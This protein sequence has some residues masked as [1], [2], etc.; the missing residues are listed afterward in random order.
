MFAS[1]V[2]FYSILFFLLG[3]FLASLGFV[4]WSIVF[5]AVLISIG[6]LVG[7]WL[8]KKRKFFWPFLF[9]LP[10]IIGFFYY[11]L[12]DQ[13]FHAVEIPFNQERI[14]SGVVVKEPKLSLTSQEIM[15]KLAAPEKGKVLIKLPRYPTLT[16]GDSLIFKG[17]IEKTSDNFYGLSLAK[18][19]ING[20]SLFPT[21]K[22]KGINQGSVF[23]SLL[24]AVKIRVIEIFRKILPAEQAAFLSGLILGDRGD[25]SANFKK[26]MNLSGTTHLIALSGYNISIISLTVMAIFLFFFSR[27]WAFI[28]TCLI[29]TGFVIMTGAE[30]SVVRAAIMGGLALLAQQVGRLYSVRNAIMLAAFIMVLAN[31]K[32]L[33]FDVG[34]QLSFCALLGIVYLKPV[35]AGLSRFFNQPGFL[36]WRDNFLT[37]ASAQLVVLPILVGAFGQFSLTSLLAN[38]LILELIP[39]TMALG[40]LTAGVGFFS[41]YLSLVLGWLVFGLLWIETKIIHWFAVLS[42]PLK[43]NFSIILIVLYYLIISL[44]ILYRKKYVL[45]LQKD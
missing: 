10:V 6:L 16:Y 15:V 43:I 39:V 32:V 26:M 24:I 37:T 34:F 11:R 13:K 21:I 40:F 18:E 31:P 9:I 5:A 3:I 19:K 42:V 36:A 12:D 7:F 35:L 22:K 2:F 45:S 20:I 17:R 30:A 38:V 29:I 27:R 4:F 44:F 25:F 1:G 14:F 33:V 23:K 8:L 41:Y 28:M